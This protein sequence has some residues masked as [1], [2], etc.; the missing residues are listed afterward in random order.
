MMKN[1]HKKKDLKKRRNKWLKNSD[2]CKSTEAGENMLKTPSKPKF[3]ILEKLKPSNSSIVELKTLTKTVAKMCNNFTNK[4]LLVSLHR[5]F[6]K[7]I[8]KSK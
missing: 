1:Y 4:G 7:K 8:M 5:E 2:S 6:D 3:Q